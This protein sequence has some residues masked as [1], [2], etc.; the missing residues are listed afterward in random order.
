[1]PRKSKTPEEI[2]ASVDFSNDPP[3]PLKRIR[4]QIETESPARSAGLQKQKLMADGWYCECGERQTFSP[5]VIAHWAN[6]TEHTCQ[7]CGSVHK[8]QAG[9]VKLLSGP[10]LKPK[11]KQVEEKPDPKAPR[12]ACY[13]ILNA[14]GQP[15]T[16]KRVS[17]YH[18]DQSLANNEG[19]AYAS[20]VERHNRKRRD[21][22]YDALLREEVFPFG[23]TIEVQGRYVGGGALTGISFSKREIDGEQI[24]TLC[25]TDPK[26]RKA[27]IVLTGETLALIRDDIQ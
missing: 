10:T 26:G 19:Y 20:E 22:L 3:K 27:E 6:M 15:T 13:R 24:A 11:K 12:W 14:I 2:I 4:A 8:L 9:T 18:A 17:G 21:D 25:F 7:S 5:W 16:Y 23:N 1:M